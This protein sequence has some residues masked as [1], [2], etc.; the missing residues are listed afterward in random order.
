MSAQASTS[1]G[2][3]LTL[4]RLL[5]SLAIRQKVKGLFICLTGHRRVLGDFRQL[6]VYTTISPYDG[7]TANRDGTVVKAYVKPISHPPKSKEM[8]TPTSLAE[9]ALG[10]ALPE[11]IYA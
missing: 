7:V 10:G 6:A 2:L 4:F 9:V 1:L 11:S 3:R 8:A 5:A